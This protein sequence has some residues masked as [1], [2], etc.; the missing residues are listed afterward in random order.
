MQLASREFP[1]LRMLDYRTKRETTV[2]SRAGKQRELAFYKSDTNYRRFLDLPEKT[3]II[4]CF[5]AETQI[6]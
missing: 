2:V 5:R 6:R 3:L 4:Y 1:W